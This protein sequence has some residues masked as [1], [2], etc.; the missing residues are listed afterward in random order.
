[1]GRM[2][3][4]LIRSLN[5]LYKICQAGAK[6][7]EAVAA[8]A[9]NTGLK[10]LLKGYA[11]QRAQFADDLK[12]EIE[13]LGGE[14][15]ERRGVRG[16]VHRG[17]IHILANFTLGGANVQTFVLNEALRGEEGAVGAYKRILAEELPA[18]MRNL[19]ERQYA[20]VQ[21]AYKQIQLLRGRADQR[22]FVQLFETG[23]GAEAAL[24]EL[25]QAGFG[26]DSIETEDVQ[27]MARLHETKNSIA[28]EA[29][30]SGAVGGAIWGSIVGA[31]AGLGALALAGNQP[32]VGGDLQRTW[33]I[34]ALGGTVI[35]ALIGAIL[36]LIV[37]L[38]IAEE[39]SYLYNNSLKQ[40]TK[41]LR[42]HTSRECSGE[43][44]HILHHLDASGRSQAA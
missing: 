20:E 34:I 39:H 22:M 5:A 15:S 41:L 33:A 6:G 28:M 32:M 16:I 17:R 36:G 26:L 3:K 42:L 7:F 31:T 35:G 2:D 8:N 18:G 43:A 13:H 30:I 10:I 14:V 19:V 12:E 1:M 9:A 11:Q 27:R 40:G 23:P 25:E 24:R 21:D 29:V 38:S 44:A 4:R 37:G